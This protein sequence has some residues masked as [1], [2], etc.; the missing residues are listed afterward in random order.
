MLAS[1]SDPVR[2]DLVIPVSKVRL[3]RVIS[4][5]TPG[6]A[7]PSCFTETMKSWRNSMPSLTHGTSSSAEPCLMDNPA[8]RPSMI[9]DW[10]CCRMFKDQRTADRGQKTATL[11]ADRP[12]SKT[13]WQPRGQIAGSGC[14]QI[15]ARLHFPILAGLDYNRKHLFAVYPPVPVVA[16]R[17]FGLAP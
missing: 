15:Q 5:F 11:E 6:R 12:H 2:E 7:L 13:T 10:R 4:I 1:P 16:I 9:S 17:D 3:P 8:I 14:F